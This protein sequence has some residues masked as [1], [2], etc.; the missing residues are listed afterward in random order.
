MDA[1][2]DSIVLWLQNSFNNDYLVTVLVSIIPMIECRG[3]ITIASNL[4]MNVWLAYLLSCVS[5]LIVCPI[6]ILLLKPILTAMKKVK[7]F[8]K[9]ALSVE[10][11]FQDKAD[12]LD[13]ESQDKGV[14]RKMLG[15]FLFVAIP[16][17]MTGVW[18]GTAVAVFLN[19]NYKYSVPA[20]VVGNFVAG[21]IITLLNIILGDKSSLIL[22]VLGLFV[23]ITIVSL[24]VTLFVKKGKKVNDEE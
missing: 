4:G 19:L 7:W 16:L 2:I 6:L 13:L 5:S 22:L 1:M 8:N 14:W 3:A 17:P 11:L 23:V 9:L 12:K 24:L 18:T 15:I 20:I 10:G 21:F